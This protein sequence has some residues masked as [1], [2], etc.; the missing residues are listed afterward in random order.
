M[1]AFLS[2][3]FSSTP[4]W[5]Q[6]CKVKLT[7]GSCQHNKKRRPTP[8]PCC[9]VCSCIIPKEPSSAQDGQDCSHSKGESPR[10]PAA[11]TRRDGCCFFERNSWSWRRMLF[12]SRTVAAPELRLQSRWEPCTG[13]A[14]T[15]GQLF[16]P[17][18]PKPESYV[19]YFKQNMAS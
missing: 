18:R 5:R 19:P 7:E 17:N 8:A 15:F 16:G 2:R 9:A 10:P 1:P 14:E 6:R 11:G 4:V 13:L 3:G 12:T